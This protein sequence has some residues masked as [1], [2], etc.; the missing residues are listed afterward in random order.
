MLPSFWARDVQSNI[1][2]WHK[3][4]SCAFWQ[5]TMNIFIQRH[6]IKKIHDAPG[7]N[8]CCNWLDSYDPCRVGLEP[9]V[10][11]CS[12]LVGMVSHNSQGAGRTPCAAELHPLLVHGTLQGGLL[13]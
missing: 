4:D 9:H 1:L 13:P 5:H 8:I 7:S 12:R 2:L 3:A 6:L 11:P 10:R